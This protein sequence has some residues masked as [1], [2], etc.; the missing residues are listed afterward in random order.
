M[1]KCD[2]T[3][4]M[5]IMP[6]EWDNEESELPGRLQAVSYFSLQSYYTQNLSTRA[7]KQLAARNEGVSIPI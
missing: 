7:A 1:N 3:G 2:I 5:L 4:E 6:L